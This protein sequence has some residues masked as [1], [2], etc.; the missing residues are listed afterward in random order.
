MPIFHIFHHQEVLLAQFSLYVHKGGLKPDSFH[1]F[2]CPAIQHYRSKHRVVGKMDPSKTRYSP[3]DGLTLIHRLR[4]WPNDS[5]SLGEYIVF[6]GKYAVDI[7]QIRCVWLLTCHGL[8]HTEERSDQI[9][10]SF[11]WLHTDHNDSRNAL[12]GSGTQSL[13]G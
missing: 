8:C 2:H 4:R 6:A 1:F 12:F 13:G 9:N 7:T 5:P 3:S 10:R 11:C